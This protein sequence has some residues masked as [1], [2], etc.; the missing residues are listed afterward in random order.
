M[1]ATSDVVTS[2]DFL[3]LGLGGTN[4][5]SM[6]WTVAMGRRAV[7]VEMRGDPFLGVHWNIREDLYHQLG[8][9]DQMMLERYGEERIPRRGN[10]RIFRLAE[11]FYSPHTV[12][13]DIVADEIIDGFD[14][15]QHIV[16]TIHHIEFIDD[17]WRDGLPN[18]VITVLDPPRPPDHPDPAK[19][20]T[21][22][23]DVLDGPSTFQAEAASI[24]KL[25]RRYLERLE[26][27]DREMHLPPRVQLFTRHRVVT[28]EGDGF[29][30]CPDGRKR[31]RIEA[32]QE[33]DFKGQFVRVREPGSQVI[34]LGVPE[35]FMVAQGFN[36]TDAKRLGF[37]QHDVEVDHGDGRGPVVAQADYL[38]GLI[39][40]LIGGR[41]RRRISSE[42]D[43]D[44]KEYWVRQIAVGHE[45]DPEVG[46]VVVQVPDFKTFD[47][48]EAGLVP[49]GTDPGS[50]EFF[51][52]YQQLI[53][54]YYIRQAAD[55]LDIPRQE[56]KKVQMIYGP[57]LFSLIE[58]VGDDALVA[59]N[60][61]IAGDSFGNGHF[62]TSGGA[63]TGMIGHSSRVLEYWRERDRGAS[64]AEAIRRLA[65]R[66][67][68]DTHAWLKVSATEYS[69]A[70]PINFGAERIE[71]LNQA[72][73]ND[74]KAR[75]NL[76]EAAR[77]QRHALLPLD[78][79]NWRRLFVRNGKVLSA[80][81]E[82]ADDHPLLRPEHAATFLSMMKS[83]PALSRQASTSPGANPQEADEEATIIR[84][85]PA[86]PR[87]AS[88]SPSANLQE[89]NEEATII[90]P[91]LSIG[92]VKPE[93]AKTYAFLDIQQ[94]EQV[95]QRIAI[96]Q[97][98]VI[99]G[100][101][102]PKGGMVPE[103]DLTP[104]D[105]ARS[106]SRK[107]ARIRFEQTGCSLEDLNSRNK[108]RVG[109]RALSPYQPEGLQDGDII[110]FGMVK[111]T[112]RLLGTSELPAPFS[113]S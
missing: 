100:R 54:D 22:M 42:F 28:T 68:E 32:L 47:P 26:Q 33:F 69:Q 99:V 55:I 39:E 86:L 38:A 67:K 93:R 82:L 66:I 12:A 73:G 80:L 51:A 3:A 2:P 58:R 89:A 70:I 83:M 19:I 50:P 35:L 76:I 105:T 43:Q 30:D 72:S 7:G 109:K 94:D 63:M 111:A 37:E 107:H 44:G 31:I 112:F 36:S 21:S 113:P 77:R 65:D 27:L 74:A 59:A 18:R 97:Q 34:D 62:L 98:Q 91:R 13:G 101:G 1:N 85:R 75:A 16:G 40:V 57:T 90:R 108:T 45:N 95:V 14:V 5:M 64:P 17:R 106:V 23:V 8:L 29:I 78:P 4:M 52:A 24:Q 71:Q 46:W 53:Y 103:I 104:F 84:A 41:L 88:T 60:G 96:T 9:I 61:V 10:G 6:L 102:D 20:R 48:I 110:S 79:S 49:A 92:L 56:L 11:C 81:P 15:E 25:L 87:Q